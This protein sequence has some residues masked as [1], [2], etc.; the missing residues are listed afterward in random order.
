[1]AVRVIENN[2]SKK[3]NEEKLLD[4]YLRVASL[5]YKVDY[6]N[7]GCGYT[8]QL[9]YAELCHVEDD[10]DKCYMGI[11]DDEDR[12]YERIDI[13][14]LSAE[15]IRNIIK[16]KFNEMKKS[17][18]D[19]K[20]YTKID[21]RTIEKF[22]G[23]VSKLNESKL[24]ESPDSFFDDVDRIIDMINDLQIPLDEE[25]EDSVLSA[26]E[27]LKRAVDDTIRDYDQF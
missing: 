27:R 25:F 5:T 2:S 9:G 11:H 14:G 10:K 26:L 4:I 21:F 18:E 15:E 8:A 7:L 12:T 23:R 6:K 24:T 17:H 3:L 20:L 16:S 19:F 1:M 13:T 22:I